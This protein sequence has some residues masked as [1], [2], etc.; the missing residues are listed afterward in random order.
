MR[1]SQLLII[2]PVLAQVALSLAVCALYW[3]RQWSNSDSEPLRTAYRAQ[4]ELPVLFYAGSLFAYAVRIVDVGI[5][6]FAM[7]FALAQTASVITGLKWANPKVQF[8]ADA[9]SVLAVAALWFM[10][11]RYF[12]FSG[13]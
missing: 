10:I 6:F 5:L 7:L 8:T 2:V 4:F 11:A 9:L 13:F 12:F 1:V 3:W